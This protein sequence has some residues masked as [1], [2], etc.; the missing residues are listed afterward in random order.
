LSSSPELVSHLLR[1]YPSAGTL[2]C[3]EAIQKKVHG[4]LPMHLGGF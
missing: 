2:L 4:L 3:L 1:L